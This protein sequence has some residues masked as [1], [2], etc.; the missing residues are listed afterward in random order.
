MQWWRVWL[1]QR[2]IRKRCISEKQP[3]SKL[4]IAERFARQFIFHSDTAQRITSLAATFLGCSIRIRNE[5]WFRIR[6]LPACSFT[7][8]YGYMAGR[9]G[10]RSKG[11]RFNV[12][13]FSL[14]KFRPAERFET[15]LAHFHTMASRA[16]GWLRVAS[17]KIRRVDVETATIFRLLAIGTSQ[18]EPRSWNLAVVPIVAGC[19]PMIDCLAASLRG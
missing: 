13:S 11:T 9:F 1:H 5:R 19:L 16:N 4:G 17:L 6:Y 15:N 18:L 8:L 2:R 3:V 10:A 7:P 12:I 14:V